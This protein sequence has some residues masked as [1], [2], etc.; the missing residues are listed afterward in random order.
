MGK[1]DLE[2]KRDT[3]QSTVITRAES[4]QSKDP[5]ARKQGFLPD[6]PRGCRTPR[7]LFPR[8][9]TKSWVEVECPG[10]ELASIWGY[11]YL[12]GMPTLNGGELT[13]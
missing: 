13:N 1:A 12:Y 11:W 3:P 10:C 2:R 5:R 6:C 4:M 7:L 8:S 9:Q